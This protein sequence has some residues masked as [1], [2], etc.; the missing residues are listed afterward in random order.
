MSIIFISK[1]YQGHKTDPIVVGGE[2]LYFR[3]E[4]NTRTTL[5]LLWNEF[6]FNDAKYVLITGCSAGGLAV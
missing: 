2:N 1:G 4:A 6:G 5:A 3:G